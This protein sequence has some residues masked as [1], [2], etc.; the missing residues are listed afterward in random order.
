[1]RN[2]VKLTVEKIINV[3]EATMLLE[4]LPGDFTRLSSVGHR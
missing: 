2:S 4:L 3:D 1:V